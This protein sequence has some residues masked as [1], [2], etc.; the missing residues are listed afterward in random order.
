MTLLT[1]ID[2]FAPLPAADRQL[3]AEGMRRVKFA[4]GEQIIRQ[5]EPSD[6]LYLVQSGEVRVEL[7]AG[8]AVSEL[9]RL[10]P[11]AFFGE[12]SLVTGAPCTAT[13]AAISDVNC[14]VVDHPAFQ[15][16]IDERPEVAEEIS[17]I[18]AARQTAL[19]E[20]GDGLSAEAQSRRTAETRSHLVGRIRQFFQVDG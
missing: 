7:A 5:D 2:L 17:T 3:I 10:G 9:A 13:C 8:G 19:Q 12:M 1:R 15:R 4:V 20:A 6:L 16:L 11:G 14:F 18:L